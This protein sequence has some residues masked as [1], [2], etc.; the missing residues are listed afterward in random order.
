MIQVPGH[1]TI[2]TVSGRFGAF[3]VGHLNLEIGTFA[4]KDAL[5]EEYSEGVYQGIFAIKRIYAGSYNTGNRFI[6]ETRAEL[7]NLWLDGVDERP[8]E[9]EE[10]LDIDPLAEEREAQ[11]K[12]ANQAPLNNTIDTTANG[13]EEEPPLSTNNDDS[14][15]ALFGELWPLGNIVKLN[16]EMGRETMRAQV[17]YLKRKVNGHKEWTFKPQDKIWVRNNT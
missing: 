12:L 3:N 6:I 11:Q 2:K 1:L 10:P 16:P 17:E 4:V 15:A 7:Q 5:L 13:Q 8:V 9:A 14:L